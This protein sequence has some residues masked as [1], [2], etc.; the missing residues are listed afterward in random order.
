VRELRLAGDTRSARRLSAFVLKLCVGRRFSAVRTEEVQ[1]AVSEAFSNAS[2]HGHAGR[3]EL[4]IPVRAWEEGDALVV[5][6]SDAGSGIRE[7]PAVPDL[8]RKI[9]GQERP[10]GWGVYLMC[11]FATEVTFTCRRPAGHAVR[12]RFDSEAPVLPVVPRILTVDGE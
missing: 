10:A 8:S 1:T 12:L 5:E 11:S 6:V 4:P 3:P 9:A 7:V 2:R